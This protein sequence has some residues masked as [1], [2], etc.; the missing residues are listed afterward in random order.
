MPMTPEQED[1]FS[2]VLQ[3][4]HINVGVPPTH[5]L[6]DWETNFLQDQEARYEKYGANTS[7]S[8]K[9]WAA[10]LKI[11]EVLTNGRPPRK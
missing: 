7:F 10:I 9:Q 3:R 11:E 2:D 5:A 1:V 8:E 4:A 6:N